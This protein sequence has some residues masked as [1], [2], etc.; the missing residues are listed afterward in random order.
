[1]FIFCVLLTLVTYPLVVIGS[2][3]CALVIIALSDQYSH[4]D[5]NPFLS[6]NA[7]YKFYR[8]TF[9]NWKL[10]LI[11]WYKEESNNDF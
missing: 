8:K 10:G 4:N 7:V 3:I 11:S 1:M 6:P 2:L 5:P 9:N